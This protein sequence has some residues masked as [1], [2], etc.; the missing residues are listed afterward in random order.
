MVNHGFHDQHGYSHER[1]S[2]VM[3]VSHFLPS[4]FYQPD[5]MAKD[6]G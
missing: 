1:G 3:Q 2:M 6:D 4:I 5:W